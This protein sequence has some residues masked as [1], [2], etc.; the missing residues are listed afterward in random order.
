[1]TA[2]TIRVADY[3]ISYLESIAVKD[4]F[5]VSGG[6]SIFLNDALTV[7]TNVNYY[8]CHHE[9]AVAMASEGYARVK[10][11]IGVSLVTTGPG[12]TNAV[13]GVAGSWM[14]SVPHLIISG[15]V[16]FNQTIRNTGV[17]QLGVQ[18]I[19]IIDI[20]KPITKYAVM[21][22]DPKTIKY[23]LQKAV[24]IAKTGRPGP[25]WVDIP[26]DIQMAKVDESSLVEFNPRELPVQDYDSS[27]NLSE[28]VASVVELLKSAQRPLLHV[29]QGVKIS[30]SVRE[31]MDLVEKYNIPF[32]TA[33]NANDIVDSSH[34]L[35]VGRP[36]TFAQRAG[37][38]AVQNSDLYIAIG[39]RLSLP[40]TGYNSKD[41]A[42]NAVRVMV[43]IDK[44]E[45]EKDSLLLDIKIHSDA[46]DFLRELLR[47]LD[48]EELDEIKSEGNNWVQICQTWKAKYP[49]VLLEYRQLQQGVN[50]YY[51]ADQLSDLLTEND[52][53][54]TDMGFAFQT[55]HQ[56]F[57]VK[58]GQKLFTN[59]GLAGMGWGLPAAIGAS[60]AN[61]RNNEQ[62]NG[63]NSEIKNKV[64]CIAG[65]GG[66]QMNL[67]ELATMSHNNL[68]IK[69]FVYNNDG[70]LTIKQTQEYGFNGRL[71]GCNEDT[72]LSF[73]DLQKVAEAHGLAFLRIQNQEYLKNKI[74]QVIN[75]PGP[76]VCEVIMEKDQ[77]QIPKFLNRKTPEG[78]TIPTPLE[79]LYPYLDAQEFAENMVSAKD[80]KPTL[81]ERFLTQYSHK[82]RVN[83]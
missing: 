64:I 82:T 48:K 51:F 20:V 2:N 69:L 81:R 65:E 12:G 77:Q 30:G 34:R 52:I 29:G 72:G 55:T 43:D 62:N 5:T 31:F 1:M 70:Y 50:S 26:A 45:L 56:A 33:R 10:G 47:Q 9:Q 37:N 40:Q 83:Q 16:F 66:L 74:E 11:D 71:M 17:R 27:I 42:R 15:Q 13:T 58:K 24:Y 38:F 28:K 36:G 22:T 35:F 7:N 6:G 25:V 21:V 44:A 80:E 76:I 67:Q 18:E 68:P 14:D 73:P 8:C 46:K 39:T 54:V 53:I 23:H 61:S 49:V 60:I 32:V 3:I 59:C 78:K 75:H 4:L 63:K 57:K 79:D 41:Y 19:N